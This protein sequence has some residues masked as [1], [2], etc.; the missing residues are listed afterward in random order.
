[1]RFQVMFRESG[2][3]S[4]YCMEIISLKLW[5]FRGFTTSYTY[6]ANIILLIGSVAF[7]RIKTAKI[8]N[9]ILKWYEINLIQ[10]CIPVGCVPTAHWPYAAVFFPGGGVC[11]VP[12]GSAWSWGGLP[13]LGG[14]SAWSRGEGCSPW[15]GGFSLP[16][17]GGG[18]VLPAWGGP[19]LE[20]PPVNRITDMCK[21]ITLAT[22]SLRPL[23]M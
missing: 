7:H 13:G 17:G 4:S 20:T 10:E 15:S 9:C 3:K 22:T 21:N 16:G 18:G 19:W 5:T 23:K 12:G 1:M 6:I 14:G 2:C 11:L 8:V